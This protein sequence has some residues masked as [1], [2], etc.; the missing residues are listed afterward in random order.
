[1]DLGICPRCG[2]TWPGGEYCPNCGFIPIGAGLS[3]LP[4][5]K[6]KK[7]RPYREPGSATPLLVFLAL[8]GG[9]GSVYKS[10]P[11]EDGW[12]KVRALFGHP[13]LHDITGSW[14]VVRTLQTSPSQIGPFQTAKLTEAT[15]TFSPTAA[16]SFKLHRNGHDLGASGTYEVEGTTVHVRNVHT[17]DDGGAPLPR[18]MDLPLAWN[19]DDEVVA[20]TSPDEEI[21]LHRDNNAEMVSI[22]R[23][24]ITSAYAEDPDN[25]H[26]LLT[27]PAGGAP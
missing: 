13:R 5:K 26:S 2:R 15:I 14:E 22:R 10:K 27:K 4:K 19:G 8:I 17:D 11:W 23:D 21:Y 3:R 18:E 9:V 24:R 16:I 12:D 20:A 6:K 25:P 1:M 7:I